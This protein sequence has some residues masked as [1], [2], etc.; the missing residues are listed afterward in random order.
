[1]LV[2]GST[3]KYLGKRFRK[4]KKR[5]HKSGVVTVKGMHTEI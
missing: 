5:Y 1:M 3:Q 4:R 2:K